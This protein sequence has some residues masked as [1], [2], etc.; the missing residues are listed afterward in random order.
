VGRYHVGELLGRGGMG[1]VY[2]A[3]HVDS[4]EAVALKLL[5]PHVLGDHDAMKRFLREC[6]LAARLKV[7]HVVKVNEVSEPT[8][9]IPFIAMERLVGRD[10]AEVLR[11]DGRM[12][13]KD[14]LQLLREVGR[15]LDAAR[16][17]GIVHRDI[18]PRNL[19][20]AT[21]AGGKPPIWKILDFGVSKLVGEQTVSVDHVVGTPS[22]MAPEQAEG[23]EVTHRTDLFALG[24]IAYRA[25]TG[26]PAFSGDSA[27]AILYQVVNEMPP[28]PSEVNPR[29]SEDVD[30]VLGIALAKDPWDRFDS[31]AE[32]ADVLDKAFKSRL[33]ETL[34]ERALRALEKNP[35]S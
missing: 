25:L 22:Y 24:V 3:V 14:V 26:R 20:H 5:H 27:A 16:A 1:E 6:Q 4:E 8:A 11:A 15:G 17:E 35:W 7:A 2:E 29:L 12:S 10:L 18:K 23:G 32:L 21:V 19:F 28:R 13:Q 30:H 33:P 9:P 31:A 34:R